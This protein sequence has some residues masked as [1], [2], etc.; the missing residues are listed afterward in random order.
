MNDKLGIHLQLI[1]GIHV[2][3]QNNHRRVIVYPLINF[4]FE[5]FMKLNNLNKFVVMAVGS[6]FFSTSM[7]NA[8]DGTITFN[9]EILSSTCTVSGV[10]G[11]GGGDLS[12]SLPKID[13]TSLSGIGQTAGSTMFGIKVGAPGQAGCTNGAIA[14]VNFEPGATV[15]TATGNLKNTAATSPAGNVQVSISN[16]DGS[17]INIG[18]ANLNNKTSA[19]ISN[20]EA[21]LNYYAAYNTVGGAATA[22]KV[23]SSVMYSIAYN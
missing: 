12:V 10:G 2:S 3:I 15:D 16:T 22:G 18:Q 1:F 21:F 11:V 13:A 6:V 14:S 9:G 19:T 8:A 17:K 7:V 23:Q 5:V 4:F 20:N